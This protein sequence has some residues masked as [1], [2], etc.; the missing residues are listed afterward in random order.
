M[1]FYSFLEVLRITKWCTYSDLCSNFIDAGKNNCSRVDQIQICQ[2]KIRT[3][4]F[5]DSF[6][7][8]LPWTIIIFNIKKLLLRSRYMCYLEVHSQWKTQHPSS[9]VWQYSLHGARHATWEGYFNALKVEF[10]WDLV[11]YSY[12]FFKSFS[13]LFLMMR[14]WKKRGSSVIPGWL[15]AETNSIGEARGMRIKQVESQEENKME[16]T[17]L[18]KS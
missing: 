6:N 14:E 2:T 8:L 12:I 5:F 16:R 1:A 7:F 4:F 15:L 17:S 11:F 3:H 13:L 9:W 18:C 10:S